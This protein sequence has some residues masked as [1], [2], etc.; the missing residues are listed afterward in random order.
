MKSK[1]CLLAFTLIALVSCKK[2]PID[3]KCS[4]PH[5][6]QQTTQQRL[7][8][9]QPLLL[10]EARVALENSLN[11]DYAQPDNGEQTFTESFER[12]VEIVMIDGQAWINPNSLEAV[13]AEI[14]QRINDLLDA[15]PVLVKQVKIQIVFDGTT[16]MGV[17]LLTM[18]P[19]PFL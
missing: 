3:Q 16:A 5:S 10:E 2:K 8:V 12:P 18:M 14:C 1:I 11:E 17:P 9:T 19:I 4:N 15:N 6:N 7:N 13:N